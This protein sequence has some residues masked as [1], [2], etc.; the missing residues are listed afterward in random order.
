MV[1]RQR[2]PAAAAAACASLAL[3]AGSSFPAPVAANCNQC[4]GLSEDAC[5]A[6]VRGGVTAMEETSQ[7]ALFE[8]V[9]AGD[10]CDGMDNDTCL[11]QMSDILASMSTAQERETLIKVLIPRP[12]RRR[13]ATPPHRRSPSARP[14]STTPKDQKSEGGGGAGEAKTSGS[15]LGSLARTDPRT[16]YVT[17]TCP[18]MALLDPNTCPRR[19]RHP[20]HHPPSAPLSHTHAPSTTPPLGA[21]PYQICDDDLLVEYSYLDSESSEANKRCSMCEGLSDSSCLGSIDS[22]LASLTT[23]FAIS[24]LRSVFAGKTADDHCDGLD[25]SSCVETLQASLGSIEDSSRLV[26][27]ENACSED[28]MNFQHMDKSVEEDT[29]AEDANLAGCAP[30]EEQSKGRCLMTLNAA[31]RTL[32]NKDRLTL[33]EGMFAGDFCEDKSDAECL[34]HLDLMFSSEK[35]DQRLKR[36]L[37]VCTSDLDMLVIPNEEVEVAPVTSMA[38]Q[39]SLCD[40]AAD[41]TACLDIM[42]SSVT[43]LSNDDRLSLQKVMLSESFTCSDALSDSQCLKFFDKQ[44]A[45]YTSSERLDMLASAC[46]QG[47]LESSTTPDDEMAQSMEALFMEMAVASQQG[48]EVADAAAAKEASA[49]ASASVQSAGAEGGEVEELAQD[50]SAEGMVEAEESKAFFTTKGMLGVSSLMAGVMFA[51]MAVM[52]RRDAE[53]AERKSGL[54]AM[55]LIPQ[56]PDAVDRSQYTVL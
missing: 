17:P 47:H 50:G 51:G 25:D 48:S 33:L 23:E 13:A 22:M 8:H 36:L 30:C 29:D 32:T 53:A 43:L 7:L 46:S 38:A 12:P 24:A 10:I 21:A 39:C 44:V 49:S 16:H 35:D 3:L 14:A 42:E 56:H 1:R 6:A 27:Y 20:P 5:F 55:P 37:S 52:R 45:T 31:V 11:A 4:Q 41:D 19:P 18:A 28:S 9:F 40:D 54:E 15:C 2:T 34:Q 26:A